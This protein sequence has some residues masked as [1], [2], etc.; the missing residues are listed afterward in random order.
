MSVSTNPCEY[1]PWEMERKYVED[2]VHIS[3][4]K[5][6]RNIHCDNAMHLTTRTRVS[7]KMFR[8]CVKQHYEGTIP[9]PPLVSFYLTISLRLNNCT[10]CC[11]K[12]N[13]VSTRISVELAYDGIFEKFIGLMYGYS[14]H[15]CVL[16]IFPI[17]LW[18]ISNCKFLNSKSPTQVDL[19]SFWWLR[20]GL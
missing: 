19:H 15:H 14:N 13:I 1:I 2:I 6:K 11:A 18:A 3:K 5:Y 10:N 17:L 8:K 12:N 20:S 9:M 7:E 16:S 4:N